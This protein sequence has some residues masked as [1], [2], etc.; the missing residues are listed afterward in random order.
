MFFLNLTFGNFS[1]SIQDKFSVM[2]S[3]NWDF[4]LFQDAEIITK[5]PQSC[6]RHSN[7]YIS[8]QLRHTSR[9]KM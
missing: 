2:Q 5:A 9:D 1:I 4:F 3:V 7:S 8:R 6:L